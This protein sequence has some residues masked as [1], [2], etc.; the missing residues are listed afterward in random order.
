MPTDNLYIQMFSIHGLLRARNMELGRDADTGGQIKYVVELA[1]A[2]G[3]HDEVGRVDLMTRLVVDSSVSED[4]AQTEEPIN[5]G[6]RIVR[7]QCGGRKYMRKELL[8]PHLDEY[9][10][11]TIRTIKRSGR[12]PDVFHGHYPDAGY[13][14]AMLSEVFGV[15]FIYTGHS[16]GRSKLAR[17]LD[18]GMREREIVRRYK[19]DHRIR[20]E[21]EILQRADL[22]IAST[23]QETEEQYGQYDNAALPAFAV[24][25]PGLD[26]GKFYPHYH[27]ADPDMEKN[28]TQRFARASVLDELNRFF[29][30]PD[31]PLILSL[32]RPDKR[33]N[34]AG[35]L[36]GYGEDLELQAMAN[37]AVY[38]GIRKDI[39][40]MEDNEREVLTEIL[41]LM[42]KYDLYGK[43]AIPK[44]HDF[45][46]EVPEMYRLA[47]DK[48]GVFVNPALTEPFGI[49]LIE[50]AACGLPIVAPADGGPM[51]IVGN[52]NNGIL[53]DTSGSE[54]IAAAARRIIADGEQWKRFSQSGIEGVQ[55]HYTWP[56]HA[57]AYV[58]SLQETVSKHDSGRIAVASPTDAI[59]RR[60][61]GIDAFLVTDID[62]TLV[63]GED[64]ELEL[65]S[66]VALLNRHR[67]SIAF[68]VAT[69]RNLDSALRRLDRHGVPQPDVIIAAAGSEI[70]YGKRLNYG[71]GWETHISV[72]WQRDRI[73][74]LLESVTFLAYRPDEHQ[75]PFKIS[76]EMTPG[77]DRLA[78][79][80]HR[81]LRER[82]RCTLVT[83]KGGTFLDILPHRASKGKAVR[84]LS[85]QWEIPLSNFLVCGD[86]GSDEDML[87]GEPRAV[88]VGNHS[89]EL[90]PLE[91][92]RNVFFSEKRYAAGILEGIEHYGF[93]KK[94]G[95]EG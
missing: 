73:A 15:P 64:D 38:A 2:L 76:Y 6:A 66:L 65:A 49:T 18:E 27:D 30:R 69:G 48:R 32:C 71:K 29:L 22:V 28:E 53:V 31:K 86:S 60:L 57:N 35:L 92:L 83:S 7:I 87:R 82:Y 61:S 67:Q 47:A 90:D 41:L 44:K 13:V 26:P 94:F 11:K 8:W 93:I 36:E 19:I 4:Y 45:E 58:E 34:I 42:D 40:A 62:N 95:P 79:V 75:G 9:V 25:P 89:K 81:L 59:G 55:K 39:V 17:L 10:D 70:Y 23:R 54:N 43:I 46:H 56:S 78:E 74:D 24:I 85:Y 5:D 68:G 52:C 14:A 77:K 80:Q 63:G 3:R 1:R 91:G 51:D 12:I 37:L 72:K 20:M 88:V 50:S 84:Y 16:L 33:K 21:E